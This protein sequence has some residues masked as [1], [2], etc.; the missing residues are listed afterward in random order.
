MDVDE[1]KELNKIRELEALTRQYRYKQHLLFSDEP[2][3]EF[4]LK[5][6]GLA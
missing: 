1:I 5:E 2:P 6:S 4:Y 3:L